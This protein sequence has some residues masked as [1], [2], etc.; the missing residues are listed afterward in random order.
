[1]YS[2][3]IFTLPDFVRGTISPSTRNFYYK[4]IVAIVIIVIVNFVTTTII[5]SNVDQ[6]FFEIAIFLINPP[7]GVSLLMNS[8]GVSAIKRIIGILFSVTL[9][10]YIINVGY[11]PIIEILSI[12]TLYNSLI[13]SILQTESGSSFLFSLFA[14]YYFM[15]K[16]KRSF[17]VALI[18]S[19]ISFKRIALLGLI[20]SISFY[21]YYFPKQ[22]IIRQRTI[23]VF[24]I[25][26]NLLFIYSAY[27]ISYS[28][29]LNDLSTSVFGMGINQITM[30]RSIM[31]QTVFEYTGAYSV[32]G[33][34]LGYSERLLSNRFDVYSISLLH[35][36][37]LKM[38][39][40][41]GIILFLYW[42]YN[43]TKIFSINAKALGMVMMINILFLTDNTLIYNEVML[44][45]YL[46]SGVLI[47]EQNNHK[48][49]FRDLSH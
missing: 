40:E 30:G 33:I 43:L 42:I 46:L 41:L 14:M 34:G 7:L 27:L 25:L 20:I 18:F 28:F 1:M 4:L 19:I 11:D 12:D 15:T 32:W 35:S 23:L 38:Y 21:T 22:R 45:F 10:G 31:F 3:I 49:I 9:A 26:F 24:I 2:S 8:Y 36:D 44:L 16:Q 47:K 39:F 17:F 13:S 29:T 37:I 6:R 5:Y 48:Q